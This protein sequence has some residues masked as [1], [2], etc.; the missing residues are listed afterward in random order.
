MS[1]SH[2]DFGWMLVAVFIALIIY[3]AF[4]PLAKPTDKEMPGSPVNV[5]SLETA[6]TT[7]G[8]F[9][10]GIGG[11]NSQVKYYSY[12]SDDGGYRLKEFDAKDTTLVPITDG[13]QPR[14]EQMFDTQT[15]FGFQMENTPLGEY[16]L[17]IPKNAIKMKFNTEVN[18]K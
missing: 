15:L 12:V 4:F 16:K 8:S 2:S 9:F 1:D 18:G 7:Q 10:L 6:S 14:Y 3:Y 5:Y 11:L 13:G 17:Y